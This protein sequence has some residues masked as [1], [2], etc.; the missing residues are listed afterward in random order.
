[1]KKKEAPDW[2]MTFFDVVGDLEALWYAALWFED[3]IGGVP[4]MDFDVHK[5]QQC[6]SGGRGPTFLASRG[7]LAYSLAVTSNASDA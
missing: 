4:E 1:M 5:N 6:A 2:H 7:N 3:R